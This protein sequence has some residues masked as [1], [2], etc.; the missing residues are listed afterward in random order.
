MRRS[1]EIQKEPITFLWLV[2]LFF[3]LGIAIWLINPISKNV[4]LLMGMTLGWLVVTFIRSSG[5][6]SYIFLNKKYSKVYIWIAVLFVY[7][8]VGHTD[9]PLTYIMYT[10]CFGIGLYY[11]LTND[12]RAAWCISCTCIVYYLAICAKTL[13]AYIVRPGISRV[14][15]SG[16]PELIILRGGEAYLTPFIAGYDA[17]Y[18]MV[19]LASL[20]FYLFFLKN[21]NRLIKFAAFI[22]AVLFSFVVLKSEYSF[23]VIL[24]VVGLTIACVSSIRTANGKVIATL[25]IIMIVILSIGVGG[26][27]FAWLADKVSSGNYKLRLNEIAAALSGASMSTESDLGARM[28][29]Y[30]K[31][32][33]NFLDAPIFGKGAGVL[34][35]TFGNHSTFLDAF[36]KYGLVGAIPFIMYYSVPIKKISYN[37]KGASSKVYKSVVMLFL[38]MMLLNRGDTRT[39]YCIVYILCPLICYL[40]EINRRRR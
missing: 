38:I 22:L 26:S 36:A 12:K 11:I 16:D 29:L 25:I 10:F 30:G 13:Q 1:K 4:F 18:G 39:N 33:S 27:F 34:Y 2:Q 32:I 28:Y 21:D 8:L 9:F 15:A 5:Y 7:S 40:A 31:S 23:A 24:L 37:L 14:L 6:L 17:I 3:A 35:E 19:I 20:F